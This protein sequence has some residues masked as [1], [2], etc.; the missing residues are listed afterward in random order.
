MDSDVFCSADRSAIMYSRRSLRKFLPNPLGRCS[1][2][3]RGKSACGNADAKSDHEP[4]FS[5]SSC[6]SSVKKWCFGKARSHS[7][8]PTSRKRSFGMQ[9]PVISR[10]VLAAVVCGVSSDTRASPFGAYQRSGKSGFVPC[11]RSTAPLLH[12]YTTVRHLI[13]CNLLIP[14]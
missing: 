10:S 3:E 11:T 8:V 13:M 5:A 9:M 12:A 2:R 7:S 6:V 4:I 14:R 1:M